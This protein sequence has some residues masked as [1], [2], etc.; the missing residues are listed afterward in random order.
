MAGID[1]RGKRDHAS[2]RRTAP[3]LWFLVAAATVALGLIVLS[4][5]LGVGIAPDTAMFAAP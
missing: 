2:Y 4:I 5:A 1:T 3:D